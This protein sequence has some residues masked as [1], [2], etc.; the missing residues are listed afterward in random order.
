MEHKKQMIF[1]AVDA[2]RESLLTAA[3]DIYDHPEVGGQEF[4]A[5]KL[6]NDF[7]SSNGFEVEI[8]LAGLPTAFR[9]VW[10][11]GRGGPSIGQ[12]PS[13]ERSTCWRQDVFRTLTW[14]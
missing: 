2:Q 3:D 12:R 9:A 14:L 7:L 10:Q 8:G 5:S 4:R 6:L 13:A 1:A 11:C